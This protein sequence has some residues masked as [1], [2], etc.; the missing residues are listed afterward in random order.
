MYAIFT[1][2]FVGVEREHGEPTDSAAILLD[3]EQG[4]PLFRLYNGSGEKVYEL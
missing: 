1:K 2:H 3:E 4:S